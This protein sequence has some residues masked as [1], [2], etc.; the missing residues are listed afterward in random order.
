MLVLLS[1][2]IYLTACT[3]KAQLIGLGIR[4]TADI[5]VS[6]N[7]TS[8]ILA[9]SVLQ[10]PLATTNYGRIL[11]GSIMDPIFG[12]TTANYYSQL[13]LRESVIAIDFGENAVAESLELSLAYNGYYGDTTTFQTLRVYEINEK[14][15]SD[16]GFFYYSND[17]ISHYA[18][19]IGR[20]T[21]QPTPNTPIYLDDS[22]LAGPY[23]SINLMELTNEFGEKIIATPSDILESNEKFADYI[24]GFCIISD[25]VNEGGALVYVDIV[26]TY[27]NLTLYYSND[28]ASNIKYSMAL[29]D[30]TTRFNQYDHNNY[31]DASP[32][33]KAQVL[34]GDSLLGQDQIY[35][36]SLGGVITKIN[37]PFIKSLKGV[38]KIAINSAE[39]TLKGTEE[40]E[41][42]SAPERLTLLKIN[43]DGTSSDGIIDFYEGE[44]YFGGFHDTIN[45][46]YKFQIARYIQQ[47]LSE[48]VTDYGIALKIYG[49]FTNGGQYI[50]NGTNP[51]L[52]TP[53]SDRI[54]L[55][56]TYTI[57]E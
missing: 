44:D 24:N 40:T 11:L 23:F 32:E 25:P 42:T 41:G 28:S 56:V 9:H 13:R 49:S 43:A 48:D 45:N 55:K 16:S 6:S 2:G 4:P 29:Y 1:A 17:E 38:G 52:P 5:E 57:I 35:V 14:M 47:L 34:E 21:F 12:K 46:E 36:Q 10:E 27:S 50:L 31:L 8:S 54:K 3:K 7:D 39:L 22:L 19:E 51:S 26:S 15:N 37:F 20:T 18:T 30:S 53:Y 33:F